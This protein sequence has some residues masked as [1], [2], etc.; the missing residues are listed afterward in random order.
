[1]SWT[2]GSSSPLRNS[3]ICPSPYCPR[4]V[5]SKRSA[6]QSIVKRIWSRDAWATQVR[7][8][9]PLCVRSLHRIALTMRKSSCPESG[10]P[11][12][13]SSNILQSVESRSI[14]P[15]CLTVKMQTS[16]VRELSSRKPLARRPSCLAR[17]TRLSTIRTLMWRLV[18]SHSVS[19]L[20]LSS[21]SSRWGWCT[22]PNP[23]PKKAR[24]WH[25]EKVCGLLLQS[26]CSSPAGKPKE[27]SVFAQLLHLL[28][29]IFATL[30]LISWAHQIECRKVFVWCDWFAYMHY[31]H[32]I[33]CVVEAVEEGAQTLEQ[34]AKQF[35]HGPGGSI[36]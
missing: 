24:S 34:L 21:R 19:V 14:P 2:W 11:S 10:R 16:S 33:E 6:D 36:C 3:G 9:L 13:S 1:M 23:L 31:R 32:S 5:V 4:A 22:F 35:I 25:S 12:S 20:P 18:H 28:F 8:A 15:S 17:C 29:Q 27:I 26:W 7:H 30:L